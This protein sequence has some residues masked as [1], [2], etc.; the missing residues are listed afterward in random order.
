M[1]NLASMFVDIKAKTDPFDAALNKV[2]ADATRRGA[3]I[4]SVLGSA[5]SKSIDLALRSAHK[6][7]DAVVLGSSNLAESL[8]KTGE[9]FQGS[10]SVITGLADQMA[11][12]FGL[13]K[14]E[15]L[16]ASS[17]FGLLAQGAGMANNEAADFATGLTKLAADASSFY[18]VPLAEALQ[19]IQSGLSGEAEPLRAFGVFLSEDAVKAKALAMGLASTNGEL[20]QYA[21]IAARHMLIQEGLSKASGDLVRTQDGFANQSRMMIGSISNLATS[22]GTALMPA[23]QGVVAVGNRFI[24]SLSAGFEAAAPYI[25]AGAQGVATAVNFMAD[26]FAS[27]GEMYMQFWSDVLSAPIFQYLVDA[28]TETGG[29]AEYF[30]DTVSEAFATIAVIF[31]N[32][33]IVYEMMKVQAVTAIQNITLQI[34]A[35][36]QNAMLMGQ[37]LGSNWLNLIKDAANGVVTIFSNLGTN[38]KDLW[39]AVLEFLSTGQWTFNPTP[40]LKGMKVATAALPEMVKPMWVDASDRLAELGQELAG[41][42][43]ARAQ[44]GLTKA[45]ANYA[46]AKYGTAAAAMAGDQFKSQSFAASDFAS[47][48]QNK[49]FG[50]GN[51]VPTRQ[52]TAQE[53]MREIL[54]EQRDMLRQEIELQKWALRRGASFA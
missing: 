39:N 29:W 40:L 18:N 8:A 5:I 48:L 6:V 42:E 46:A 26:V 38:I 17:M 51:D 47:Q 43:T 3:M 23:F 33:G 20:T 1:F 54:K 2:H 15:I 4:G 27:F 30:R 13:G 19:K 21:K 28:F 32:Q 25:E 7:F 31:R 16:D 36:L 41:N 52:L 10:T 35:F 12:Q 44:P 24:S 11:N 50:S 37:W 34:D 53:Q 14:Q 45:Q 49:Q 9:V 22:I